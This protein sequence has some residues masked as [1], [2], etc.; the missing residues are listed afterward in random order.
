MIPIH[1]TK[2]AK[3]NEKVIEKSRKEGYDAIQKE[4]DNYEQPVCMPY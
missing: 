1:A 4:I 2:T 3:A